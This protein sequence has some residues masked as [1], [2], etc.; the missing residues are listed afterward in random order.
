MTNSNRICIE[1][2]KDLRLQVSSALAKRLRHTGILQRMGS[3]EN[4]ED[5]R[6]D[7][8]MQQRK[9]LSAGSSLHGEPKFQRKSGGSPKTNMTLS[10][11][12]VS[13]M[14][15]TSPC[16][17]R[18]LLVWGANPPTRRRGGDTDEESSEDE[19]EHVTTKT[20]KTTKTKRRRSMRDL[21]NRTDSL[22][23]RLFKKKSATSMPNLSVLLRR[24]GRV[25]VWVYAKPLY[26]HYTLLRDN[27]VDSTVGDHSKRNII[28]RFGLPFR[29]INM[30]QVLIPAMLHIHLETFNSQVIMFHLRGINDHENTINE[31]AS[32]KQTCSQPNSM[33]RASV[34]VCQ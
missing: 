31:R 23:R 13:S 28:T 5:N 7:S 26:K 11:P 2:D 1:I 3:D 6:L 33:Q 25:D 10:V 24:R 12:D 27:I 8:S 22:R 29:R 15:H 20:T 9:K 17:R 4:V 18:K 19:I 30:K 16:T 21:I 34:P 32:G 14:H